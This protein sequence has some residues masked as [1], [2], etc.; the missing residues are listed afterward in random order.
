MSIEKAARRIHEEW[1]THSIP[2]PSVE[3]LARIIRNELAA[4]K[5]DTELAE[6]EKRFEDEQVEMT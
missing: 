2:V 5:D 1:I 4:S 3:Y 6:I